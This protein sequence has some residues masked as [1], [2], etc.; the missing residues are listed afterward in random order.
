MLNINNKNTEKVVAEAIVLGLYQKN[1][2]TKSEYMSI[3]KELKTSPKL[4]DNITQK[5]DICM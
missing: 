5:S 3:S 4:I 2:L 1:L